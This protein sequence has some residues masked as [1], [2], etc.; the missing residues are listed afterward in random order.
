MRRTRY[1][2]ASLRI[3]VA[4]GAIIDEVKAAL[5][6]EID[7]N[8]S[9]TA[10]RKVVGLSH[11]GAYLQVQ[12]INQIFGEKIVVS[13]SGGPTGGGAYVTARGR[14]LAAAYRRAEK[15]SRKAVEEEIRPLL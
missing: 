7:R 10:A 6:E 4:A 2:V 15:K 8:G 12:T 5:I 14:E 1:P 3:E 13:N 11:N 9:L